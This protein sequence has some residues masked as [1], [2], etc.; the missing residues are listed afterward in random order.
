[1]SLSTQ[2]VHA[3]V[4]E[5]RGRRSRAIAAAA[6]L[7]ALALGVPSLLLRLA[8]ALPVD[9]GVLT[10]AGLARPDDG[11]MLL[12]A[13]LGLAWAAWAVV[14]LS[15]A[16]EV[17]AALR[18]VPTPRVPG[19]AGPQRLAA[20][21]VASMALGLGSGGVGGVEGSA[22]A[23]ESLV[24]LVMA[25]PE[26][27]GSD[28]R[29]EREDPGEDHAGV[30]DRGE[31]A[32]ESELPAIT[33]QR[34]DTLWLLAEQ[35][36]GDG[37]RLAEIIALNDGVT[38]PDGRA[39]SADGRIYPG[40]TLRLPA[41][42]DL[43]AE[44]PARHVVAPGD[45]LWEIADADLGD[46]LRYPEIFAANSGDVQ[47][48]GRRL[49]DPD[50][51]H[52]GWVLE[53]PGRTGADVEAPAGPRASSSRPGEAREKEA[54]EDR[55]LDNAE[56]PAFGDVPAIERGSEPG[57]AGPDSPGSVSLGSE[58]LPLDR[59]PGD[60]AAPGK[61]GGAGL[62]PDGPSLDG[63]APGPEAG[64]TPRPASA[65]GDGAGRGPVPR[66]ADVD[67]SV[68]SG[69][70]AGAPAA[71]V[72][73]SAG[74]SEPGPDA[75]GSQAALLVPAGGT[76]AALLLAGLLREVVRRRQQFQRHRRPGEQMPT[77]DAG[78]RAIEALG[79]DAAAEDAADLL[80][81]VLSQLAIEAHAA[82][83]DLP[84]VRTVRITST[85]VRLDLSDLGPAQGALP[86]FVSVSER[87]WELDPA[88]V[89]GA[90]KAV[91]GAS[92]AT[93]PHSVVEADS[94]VGADSVAVD[95]SS[96]GA[97]AF[98]GLVTIGTR[99]EETILL[100][101]AEV[102][103]LQLAGAPEAIPGVLR[104][105]ASELALGPAR[106]ATSRTLCLSDAAL[107]EAILAATEAGELTMEPDAA[108][109]R[110]TLVATM[111][112]GS[113][114]SGVGD[115]L[116]LVLS[117]CPVLTA[118][119]E[120]SGA[121]L[122]T[123]DPDVRG[124]AVLELDGHGGGLLQPDGLMLVPQTL[125]AAAAGHLSAVLAAADVPT[126]PPHLPDSVVLLDSEG[127][128]LPACASGAVPL[129]LDESHGPAA[130]DA[131]AVDGDGTDAL[132]RSVPSLG[133]PVRR[134]VSEPSVSEPSHSKPSLST[135]PRATSPVAGR[136]AEV[137]ARPADTQPAPR[138][139]LLGEVLVEHAHGRAES[140]RIGR[141][142]ETAAFILLN[143]G[144]R[145]SELQSALWPGRRSN[146]QTC[147]QMISRARTWLGRTSEGEP[148]LM[149]FAETGGRLRLRPEVG[150]DWG[151]F[152]QLAEAGLADPEDTE[153][154]D[155]A[156]RLVRGRPFGPVAAREMPWADLPL[157]DMICLITDVAHELAIR[158][159]RA[160]RMRAARDAAL[161][162]LRTE[163]GSEVLKAV[164][165]RTASL[166]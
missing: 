111:R 146:P 40:W 135:S 13:L 23:P 37:T 34:H 10:P 77:L 3:R 4:P 9:P 88:L 103:T 143:P 18:R 46:P 164:A 16:L 27:P 116:E 21:L 94:V 5:P 123:T 125:G 84:R 161:R 49:E 140:T 47:P 41:D 121:A 20:A 79:R 30:L 83:V 91:V 153:H 33:T 55:P 25:N 136:S 157:N 122:I 39:L 48:D 63:S 165:H 107:S 124:G 32:V 97:R 145:P 74:A 133:L 85:S 43:R 102:G 28:A 61:A 14:V 73:D 64:G 66:Q 44:R 150:S 101:L 127:A 26:D 113:A 45:T 149:P 65:A 90:P 87:C 1:M 166:P 58:A 96:E 138:I 95:A 70:R 131:A 162:G 141:L 42:A 148:H 56:G 53:I 99:G 155:A 132:S 98:P 15:V 6:G 22:P 38:Q 128:L 120:R 52:P 160:G 50:L 69:N 72:A 151:E 8:A 104:A 17:W 142:A 86:P 93:G 81:R 154:L 92:S 119:P 158:H 117:D 24:A 156:L 80:D 100:D 60:E 82:G 75:S 67:E 11:G 29:A 159:E 130:A 12:V 54:A 163:C 35:H 109:V 108:R 106:S 78:A 147:R 51:I 7:A 105:L 31:P 76:L 115:P 110:D 114:G 139:L 134:S 152:Q 62:S 36:L 2:P 137:A 129:S 112:R 144:A 126:D 57:P 68:G 89:T 19:L 118:V 71:A 59:V